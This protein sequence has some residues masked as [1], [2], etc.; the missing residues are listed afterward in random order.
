M[1]EYALLGPTTK[2]SRASSTFRR[3]VFWLLLHDRDSQPGG[4]YA[5]NAPSV[6]SRPCRPR[7]RGV[8]RGRRH[9]GR[10]RPQGSALSARP[11][12]RAQSRQ[13]RQRGHLHGPLQ[14]LLLGVRGDALCL[15][16]SALWFLM[17]A[18]KLNDPIRK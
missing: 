4:L 1:V 2:P 12:A 9:S 8:H 18:T 14:P 5:K 13:R 10:L 7:R 17:A 3:R 16:A 6:G 15:G 11:P